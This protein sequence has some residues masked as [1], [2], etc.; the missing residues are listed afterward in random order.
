[1]KFRINTID[2]FDVKGKTVLL[3]VDINEPVDKQKDMLKDIT[4]IEGCAPTIKELGDKGARLVVLAHQGSD[5]EYKNYYNLRPHAK[6]LSELTGKNITF[7][8]DVCGPYAIEQIKGLKDGEIIL[9][10]NVRFMAE[11]M[12]L[13][14]TKL[15]LTPEQ[16]AKTL[17]VE[18]LAPLGDLFVVDA[19]AAA[20]RAQPSLIAF[21]QLLPSAMGRLFEKEYS[22]LAEILEEPKKPLVF[23]LGGAKIQ[24]AFLMM[25]KVLTEGIADKVLAGGLVGNV[26]LI[27][28]G[29]DI[30]KPS[31][32]FIM[33]NNL[34]EFIEKTK[35]ILRAFGDKIVL[36][37]D[38]SY[39]DDQRVTVDVASLPADEALT[40]IGEKTAALFV[41]EIMNA[42]TV[43]VNGPMGIFEKPLTEYGTKAV[44]QALADTKAFT[45]LGGGDSVTATNKYGLANKMG[46]VCTGGGAMVRFLSGEELPV[47]AALKHAAKKFGNER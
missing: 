15:N 11:E 19:F 16:Q 21:E 41:R 14:E 18:R 31:L 30:G 9:L 39:A 35:E 38:L 13:F 32:D 5:I 10:D 26:M 40:D 27:A 34:G 47:V 3:R 45:V 25:D 12:T 17:V 33:K 2:D 44:W 37:V 4:R 8:P 24:D 43:F 7:V 6:V 42:Q 1:M 46:Y 29:V 28:K 23:V 20:H 36:P 22:V